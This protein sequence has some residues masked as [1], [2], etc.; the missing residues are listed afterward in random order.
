MRPQ[1]VAVL[2]MTGGI[3][4]ATS[5]LPADAVARIPRKLQSRAARDLQSLLTA[6]VTP[7]ATSR[8]HSRAAIAAAVGDQTVLGL[9][10]DIE[11]MDPDRP[12]AAL[13]GFLV[14]DAPRDIDAEIFYRCWTFAEA[15]FKAFQR[16]PP[17][18]AVRTVSTL[19][20]SGEAAR[21]DDGTQLL[22]RRIAD[23]FQLCLVWQAT[24]DACELRYVER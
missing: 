6:G 22:H 20:N 15:Y 14:E 7:H 17:H 2:V 21:L 13:A 10:I 24:G 9:G 11:F 1:C 8:S 19:E 23:R 3:L 4:Y 12:F 5:F 18:R 16:A